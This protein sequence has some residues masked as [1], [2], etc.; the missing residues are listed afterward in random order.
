VAELEVNSLAHGLGG[1][2]YSHSWII[3]E[4][5]DLPFALR[6]VENT[7]MNNSTV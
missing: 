7:A 6:I 5:L 1:E 4:A 2:E 3:A